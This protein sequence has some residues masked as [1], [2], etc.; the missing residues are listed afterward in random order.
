MDTKVTSTLDLKVNAQDV[1]KLGTTIKQAFDN[2]PVEAA[3]K[4]VGDLRTELEKTLKTIE[5]IGEEM[6]V[7]DR[8]GN[9]FKRMKDDLRQA[10]AEARQFK[11]AIAVSG[12]GSIAPP[13]IGRG[14]MFPGAGLA[15]TPFSAPPAIARGQ[16]FPGAGLQP[17]GPVGA[18]TGVPG[19]PAGP[20]GATFGTTGFFGQLR[21]GLRSAAGFQLPMPSA[22]GMA[23]AL[24][25]V[26][27]AGALAAGG[28]MTAAGAY[29]S[30]LRFEQARAEAAPFL[31]GSGATMGFASQTFSRR[32]PITSASPDW[33][34]FKAGQAG[35]AF[36][37][38]SIMY[39][40]GGWNGDPYAY[41]YTNKPSSDVGFAGLIAAGQR[42][43]MTP[44]QALSAAA[45]MSPGGPISARG[46]EAGLAMKQL[47]GVST[48]TTG[49]A[50]RGAV[51]GGGSEEDAIAIMAEG[52]RRGL[53][54]S[55]LIDHI[56]A[57]TALLQ[58]QTAM[59]RGLSISG[60]LG[61]QSGLSAAGVAP[62]RLGAITSEIGRSVS[63]MGFRGP[64][65]AMD[66][67]ML[68]AAGY[69]PGQGMGGYA[70]A[71]GR[72]QNDPTAA[73]G[74]YI[75]SYRSQMR[76]LDPD[77]QALL[78]QQAAA[79]YARLGFSEAGM[80]AQHGVRNGKVGGVDLDKLISTGR[81][82]SGALMPGLIGEAGLEAERIKVGGE[83]GETMRS[84]EKAT[85]K[86]ADLFTD[87]LAD[88]TE[89]VAK[90]MVRAAELIDDGI[91]ALRL[92]ESTAD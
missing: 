64:Q 88:A 42:F 89:V 80:I 70:R 10:T 34:A 39:K 29:S 27:I 8:G 50:M 54:G 43:G 12:G 68:Y 86:V 9:A 72:L 73:F 7:L 3:K 13:G 22:A 65:S 15:P 49:R 78:I 77:T 44:D 21:T 37:P 66:F 1:Q 85:L 40:P 45:G 90:S 2:K 23:A 16:M 91:K 81:D 52:V 87:N 33:L 51:R 28:L 6:S 30:S 47:F 69:S 62:Y 75:D 36:D 61:L 84:L 57:Q 67:R 63:E 4:R 48:E 20:G 76:G 58:E 83:I 74:A 19:A 31:M 56:E 53:S 82:L 60:M 17:A 55:E 32:I 38:G 18:G 5:K 26:P 92:G 14:S 59:G 71:R 41:E 25:A 24:T 35:Q 11:D 79:P 46:F